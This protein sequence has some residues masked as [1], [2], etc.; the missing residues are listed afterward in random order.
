MS[1]FP[2][3]I[4]ASPLFVHACGLAGWDIFPT[5][6]GATETCPWVGTAH[7]RSLFHYPDCANVPFSS[8]RHSLITRWNV[9]TSP[10]FLDSLGLFPSHFGV[11]RPIFLQELTIPRSAIIPR[12]QKPRFSH[13]PLPLSSV[14]L[15][16]LINKDNSSRCF[17]CS[18]RQRPGKPFL[19]FGFCA[20]V[21][22]VG[23][24]KGED[25][26]VYHSSFDCLLL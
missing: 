19:C 4:L 9:G 24:S 5:L 6:L 8:S 20:A 10:A 15:C 26:S 22:I 25:R 21:R 23:I 17:R 3:L 7:S 1:L 11:P 16:S 2:T 12:T 13:Y 18:S 14:R